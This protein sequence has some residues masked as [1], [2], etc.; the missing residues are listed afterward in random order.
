MN[1]KNKLVPGVRVAQAR[2]RSGLRYEDPPP[3]TL[4]S[5]DGWPLTRS[6]QVGVFHAF[7]DPHVRLGDTTRP[8]RRE[9]LFQPGTGEPR[10]LGC[11]R[12][13]LVVYCCQLRGSVQR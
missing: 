4:R 7:G 8:V 3:F 13:F 12:N 11:R 10:R 5:L 2:S 6:K 1:E 9:A